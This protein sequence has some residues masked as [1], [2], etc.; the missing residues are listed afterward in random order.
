MD[1]STLNETLSAIPFD[2]MSGFN[3]KRRYDPFYYVNDFWNDVSD[4]DVNGKPFMSG[5]PFG[6]VIFISLVIFWIR[7]VGPKSM[8]DRDP[9]DMKPY[10][11]VINGLTF[12]GYVTGFVTGMVFNNWGLTA[13]SCE[14]CDLMDRS[15]EMY[16]R[17][18]TGYVFFG[19]KVWELLRPVLTVYRKRDHEITNL[20]LFHCFCSVFFVFLG[21]K[22]YP[23]GVFGFLPYLDGIYQI[24]AHAYLIMT[25]A[26]DANMKPS[27]GY[28]V[29]LYRLKIVSG[30]LVFLHGAYFV[31]QPNCGPVLL[32]WFQI[33]YALAGLVVAPSEWNK[34][35]EARKQSQLMK[36][37][38]KTK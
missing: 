24:F 17:K 27:H 19:G 16:I 34:M 20:Y 30:V 4:P 33:I 11:L 15:V 7:V 12:G 37:E 23:G 29:F 25:C 1:D 9:Y 2:Y 5:G 38:L 14:A 21:L 26:G 18:S 22:L 8:R 31:T 6:W 3:L 10:L 36:L 32:K 13:F 28:R 35:Q